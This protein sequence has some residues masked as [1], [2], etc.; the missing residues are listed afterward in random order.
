MTLT[1][2]AMIIMMELVFKKTVIDVTRG[3]GKK[4][5]SVCVSTEVNENQNSNGEVIAGDINRR[6]SSG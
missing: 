2:M 4:D 3:L 5:K 6:S 1:Q